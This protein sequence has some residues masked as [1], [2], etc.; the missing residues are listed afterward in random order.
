MADATL[1]ASVAT[2][3]SHI[4]V[5]DG[6]PTTTTQAIAD[7]YGKRHDDVLRVVRKRMVEAGEWGVR[8]FTDTPYTNP[9]NGQTYPVIRMTRKGFHFVVGKFT[10]AKAVQH[11]IAFADEFERMEKELIARTTRPV[12]PAIDYRRIDANQAQA[13]KEE[14]ARIVASGAQGYGE[15]WARLHRKFRVNSY[16]ELPATKFHEALAYLQAKAPNAVR[17][18]Q[19]DL[20]DPAELLLS[21]QADPAALTPAQRAMIQHR[22]WELAGEACQL[23]HTHIERRVAFHVHQ[24]QMDDEHIGSVVR[25]T[26]L[27]NA[28]TH[29]YG[30][31]LGTMA[32]ILKYMQATT[33]QTMERFNADMGRLAA[34]GVV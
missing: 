6:Q 13:L 30:Q 17:V 33:H 25:G 12:D 16:L 15:T 24:T 22:A 11:Q 21:G 29:H 26:T 34:A 9:Q 23:I 5:I 27:G 20:I 31:Q 10:G 3:A 4:T 7:V 2:I 18:R 28:L 8:N 1:G 19:P 14:V 32:S